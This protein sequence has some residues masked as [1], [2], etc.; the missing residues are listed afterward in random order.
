MSRDKAEKEEKRTHTAWFPAHHPST[1]K[2]S[3]LASGGYKIYGLVVS[4]S[5]VMSIRKS[6]T[7]ISGG[8][9]AAVMVGPLGFVGSIADVDTVG[10]SGSG[11]TEVSSVDAFW[12]VGGGTLRISPSSPSSSLT[13]LSGRKTGRWYFLSGSSVGRVLARGERDRLRTA[14]HQTHV[15][16]VGGRQVERGWTYEKNYPI[17]LRMTSPLAFRLHLR[18]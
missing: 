5:V 11:F 12:D 1:G 14:L 17:V 2:P 4:R 6:T 18:T 16:K 7:Y 15:S 10:A 9:V 8:P 13:G 3:L